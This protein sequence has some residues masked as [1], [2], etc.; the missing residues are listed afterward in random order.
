MER[1]L[2]KFYSY[3]KVARLSSKP[4]NQLRGHLNR[5]VLDLLLL[6]KHLKEVKEMYSFNSIITKKLLTSTNQHKIVHQLDK[7]MLYKMH[8]KIDYSKSYHSKS[9]THYQKTYLRVNGA[10]RFS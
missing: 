9:F 6:L 1:K 2:T 4:S 5:L 3:F 8:F 10:C 7:K